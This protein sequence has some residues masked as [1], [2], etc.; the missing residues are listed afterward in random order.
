MGVGSHA[1]Q[2]FRDHKLVTRVRLPKV[3]LHA[4]TR[5]TEAAASRFAALSSAAVPIVRGRRMLADGQRRAVVDTRERLDRL[6]ATQFAR[7]MAIAWRYALPTVRLFVQTLLLTH[8]RLPPLV[9]ALGT[10]LALALFVRTMVELRSQNAFAL[11]HGQLPP[12]T[13]ATPTTSF[14]AVD[15]SLRKVSQGIADLRSRL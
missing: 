1:V 15:N 3:R 7:H 11:R 10:A 12:K 13:Q 4:G 14:A 2:R 6:L 9:A 5:A 8:R